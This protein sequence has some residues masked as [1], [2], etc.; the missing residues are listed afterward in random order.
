[1]A[2]IKHTE[3]EHS[4]EIQELMGEIPGWIIRCGLILIFLL[5]VIV[6]IGSYFF[7]Y[8]KVVSVPMVITTENPPAHLNSKS[9]GRIVHWFH[10]D[11]NIISSGDCIAL[12]NN[13]A[14]YK[15]IKYL[16]EVITQ[17][18]TASLHTTLST[19][20]LREKLVLG[21]LQD[22]Y[23]QFL[24]NWK[25]YS[26]YLE[27][28]F[29]NGKI[30]L[31]ENQLKRQEENY[32]IL[33]EQNKLME[34]ELQIEE[35][36]YNRYQKMIVKGGVSESQMDDAK[37]RLISAQR[38]FIGFQSNV[39]TNEISLLSQRR[40]IVDLKEQQQADIRQFEM[41]IAEDLRSLRNQINS[42][43]DH[44]L[45]CSPIEGKLSL[46]NYWSEN[47]V[48]QAGERLATVVP[49]ESTGIICKATV[50]HAGI[51]EIRC[52]QK[53]NV[54]LSGFPFMQYG[55]L[56]GK[57]KSISLVPN[58]KGYIVMIELK[59][60]MTSSYREKLRL[61]Q[62]M[63]GTAEIVTQDTRAIYRFIEPLR[64]ILDSGNN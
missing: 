17:I 27:T 41:N 26:N 13:L 47:H 2:E 12:I 24:R 21:D 23:N 18:D 32:Q 33:L 20:K 57:V 42:W 31:S 30:D 3:K 6:I 9:S 60:G 63:D 52:E 45:V 39:K 49:E 35:K 64:G 59:G 44:Y 48:I 61:V 28:N 5:F 43:K 29:I 14:N 40:S 15:D 54:K 16:E 38:S 10:H 62:E 11:G 1:M 53:V 19:L 34:S 56:S 22:L 58:D 46:D 50:P 51:G 8:P 55:M 37:A 25:S 7:K 4:T 36:N